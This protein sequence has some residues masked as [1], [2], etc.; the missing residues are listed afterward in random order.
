MGNLF[1]PSASFK[2]NAENSLRETRTVSQ[3]VEDERQEFVERQE[4]LEARRQ[5]IIRERPLAYILL[6][7][8]P[9]LQK[10]NGFA[11]LLPIEK[12]H[13]VPVVVTVD[14]VY[15]EGS[16]IEVMYD[17]DLVIDA[18]S[19]KKN[20]YRELL[21]RNMR[22]YNESAYFYNDVITAIGH[23]KLFQIQHILDRVKTEL[24][25][26]QKDPFAERFVKKN[27]VSDYREA[28]SSTF[29]D[30]S[31]VDLG[32]VYS[33]RHCD[34]QTPHADGMC[35]FCKSEMEIKHLEEDF[36][37]PSPFPFPFPTVPVPVP[38]PSSESSSP[39]SDSAL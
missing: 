9:R 1:S 28:L 31:G 7:S 21:V 2:K 16:R 13:G 34:G 36:P 12:F 30:I 15:K 6:Q 17:I 27:T 39:S 3:I 29:A 26:L 18:K 11:M 35:Y 20:L 33:C 19:P 37:P 25:E 14:F 32:K 10:N 4:K 5:A 38:V 22:Y 23:N 8:I 24:S